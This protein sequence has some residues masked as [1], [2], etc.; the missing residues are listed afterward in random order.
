M[1]VR[2][3]VQLGGWGP[4]RATGGA[5]RGRGAE[6]NKRKEAGRVEIDG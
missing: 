1:G 2:M 4:A 5:G 6:M 3:A